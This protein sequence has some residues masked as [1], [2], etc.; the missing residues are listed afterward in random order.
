[1]RLNGQTAFSAIAR[2]TIDKP[3][4]RKTIPI[5]GYGIAREFSLAKPINS[6]LVDVSL[7]SAR[8]N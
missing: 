7:A 4:I 3:T 1:M 6:A 8:Y 2:V 5:N